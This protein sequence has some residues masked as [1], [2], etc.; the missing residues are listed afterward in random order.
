MRMHY[1]QKD[2]DPD[3]PWPTSQKVE[4]DQMLNVFHILK[5]KVHVY[6]NNFSPTTFIVA[7]WV[8]Q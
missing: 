7:I 8:C 3:P 5:E 1:K 6:S 2:W 4:L